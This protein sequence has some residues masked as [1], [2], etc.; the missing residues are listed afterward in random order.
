LDIQNPPIHFLTSAEL[1]KAW[2]HWRGGP[3]ALVETSQRDGLD[4]SRYQAPQLG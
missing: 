2:H 4:Y 3:A 1:K